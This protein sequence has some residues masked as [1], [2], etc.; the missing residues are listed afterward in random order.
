M[1]AFI[2]IC[3]HLRPTKEQQL[4]WLFKLITAKQFTDYLSNWAKDCSQIVRLSVNGP[5][6]NFQQMANLWPQNGQI[7]ASHD[8]VICN[9]CCCCCCG[10]CC[11]ACCYFVRNARRAKENEAKL[12]VKG[13][14]KDAEK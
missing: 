1:K 11:L 7:Y 10:Y 14:K 6:E 5:E 2:Q 8:F 12:D 9:C 3:G 13:N 4:F